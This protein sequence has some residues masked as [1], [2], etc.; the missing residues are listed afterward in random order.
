MPPVNAGPRPL[1][2]EH[3][4]L[5]ELYAR[6][7]A[8]VAAASPRC[9][10]SGR[11]CDFPTS[12]HELYATDLERD[13][14][15][16]MAGGAVPAVASG[17]CPWY[18][19]GLCRL[20]DGRPLGCR[21]YFC[22]PDWAEAMPSV[23]EDFHRELGALHARFDVTYRYGRFVDTV[24]EVAGGDAAPDAPPDTGERP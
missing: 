23:Y 19:E 17:R 20:R 22:D 2:P 6:V 21:V 9:Q 3:A 24:R 1:R 10:M 18:V 14:A 4:A 13:Y 16:A 8:R 7:D 15:V 12:D 5:A 11:C